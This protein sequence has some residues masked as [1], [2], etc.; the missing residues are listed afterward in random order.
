[1][2]ALKVSLK[3][4]LLCLSVKFCLCYRDRTLEDF[5]NGTDIVRAVISKFDT[6]FSSDP[7]RGSLLWRNIHEIFDSSFMRNLAYVE[8]QDGTKPDTFR[9]GYF[10]GIW[11]VDE[12]MFD[13]TKDIMLSSHHQTIRS[14]SGIEW[15]QVEWFDLT[16]PLY[17]A[18]AAKL[19]LL[20]SNETR[21]DDYN[22]SVLCARGPPSDILGQ[23]EYWNECYHDG[24]RDEMDFVTP[25]TTLTQNQE[26]TCSYYTF[27]C[28]VCV[29]LFVCLS[30]GVLGN[31]G[32]LRYN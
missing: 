4:I 29:C 14:V 23:A 21:S 18:L 10:G 25:I 5:T 26:C 17:S 19:Y 22:I 20:L 8:S 11:Q 12:D 27:V 13:A 9:R 24:T 30:V 1:M 15:R 2:M 31:L 7:Y 6:I 32:E 3:F 16:K 28:L